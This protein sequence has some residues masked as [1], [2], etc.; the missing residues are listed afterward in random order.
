MRKQKVFS[1]INILGLTVGIT[2]CL[3][4]FLFIKHEMSYDDFLEDY[5]T[6]DA[7]LRNLEVMGEAI[8]NISKG[9]RKNHGEVEWKE[10]AGM[11]DRVIHQYFGIQWEI[12]WSAIKDKVP[13]LRGKIETILKLMPGDPG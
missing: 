12:V 5:K 7:V 4:I 10:I 1:L 6:Q 3:M 2:C 13:E 9:L 8:K 11:R